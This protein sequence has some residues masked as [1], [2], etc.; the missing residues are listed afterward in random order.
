MESI[1]D[2]VDPWHLMSS[3]DSEF[4]SEIVHGP[5]FVFRVLNPAE[6]GVST[7]GSS[8]SINNFIL[9]ASEMVTEV[10][11]KSAFIQIDPFTF[12]LKLPEN[13]YGGQELTLTLDLEKDG[14]TKSIDRKIFTTDRLELNPSDELKA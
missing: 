8:F 12:S 1:T 2:E 4:Y 6:T 14:T 13:V 10:W 5:Y 11:Q 7:L 9:T 3:T